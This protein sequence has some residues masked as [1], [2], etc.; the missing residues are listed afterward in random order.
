[1]V[2]KGEDI[3]LMGLNVQAAPVYNLP[4]LVLRELSK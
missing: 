2:D 1:M 3:D 4:E